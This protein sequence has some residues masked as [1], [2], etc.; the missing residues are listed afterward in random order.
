MF[1]KILIANRGE[2]ALRVIRACKEL[3]IDT[4]AVHSDADAD[5]LH[6]KFADE[7]VCIGPSPSNQSYLRVPSILAAAEITGADAI[8]PGYGFL[9]END[10]FA[11]V[12]QS[13]GLVWIGPQPDVIRRMGDKAQARRMMQEVDV[14]VIPGSEGVLTSVDEAVG[15]AREMGFP[16]IVK[17]VAGG[18]GRG[19]RVAHDAEE[20]RAAVP[21]ARAEAEKAFSNPDVYIEKYLARPRHI[22]VQLLGD[23]HGNVVHLGERDC[24]LQRRHQKL[25][26][27]S[28]SPAVDAKLRQ[29]LGETAIRG[30]QSVDYDSAG[31]ME[32]LLNADGRFYFMEMNTRIQVEHPVTELVTGIDIVKEQIAVAAGEELGFKQ[33]ALRFTGHAIEVRIN[34]EDPL[35]GF[36][37]SP[38][39]VEFLHMPGGIG[40][41]IDSHVYQGYEISPWYDSLIAKL[42]VHGRDRSEALARLE[43]ALAECLILGIR[44]TTEFTLD[45]VRTPMFQTGEVT[46]R[47]LES[48]LDE[49]DPAAKSV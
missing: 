7:S 41:R 29:R 4:V 40:V 3:G 16:V 33:S 24:S 6:V 9:A 49:Y 31:T 32:F 14:P 18:G 47:S 25:I 17:A 28:P 13:S 11:S 30:A 26:E 36:R 35:L 43:R 39:K 38:G 48:F 45:L 19:M 27:E 20:L 46:T 44:T 1:K 22:E 42:L 23:K 12:V 2:I 15:V 21:T 8:H 10:H 37:P 5:S 34:A